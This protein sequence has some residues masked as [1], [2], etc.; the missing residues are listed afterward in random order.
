ME[1]FNNGR[2]Q[3]QFS[4]SGHAMSHVIFS[5]TLS[6]HLSKY[7]FLFPCHFLLFLLFLHFQLF[8][9]PLFPPLFLPSLPLLAA[10][11]DTFSPLGL[12]AKIYIYIY[13]RMHNSVKIWECASFSGA[14]FYGHPVSDGYNQ[15]SCSRVH[16]LWVTN[17]VYDIPKFGTILDLRRQKYQICICLYKHDIYILS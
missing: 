11:G 3:N 8:S 10:M 15:Q 6:L 7:L 5:L 4:D 17:R 1:S 14:F 12:S 2:E 9:S 16:I 13:H